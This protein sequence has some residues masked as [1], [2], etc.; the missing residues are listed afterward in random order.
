LTQYFSLLGAKKSSSRLFL[1]SIGQVVQLNDL[2]FGRQPGVVAGL[3]LAMAAS[4]S[5]GPVP[6][7]FLVHPRDREATGF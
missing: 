4:A 5:A 6:P 3:P 7:V 1:L 2:I